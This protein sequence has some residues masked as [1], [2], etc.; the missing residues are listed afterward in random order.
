MRKL[1]NAEIA[2]VCYDTANALVSV[3]EERDTVIQ[4]L[5]TLTRQR[6][7][8][9]LAALMHT[10]GVNLDKSHEA[11]SL[12]LEKE[13]ESGNLPEIQRAVSMI[14]PNMGIKTASLSSDDASS[15]EMHPFEAFLVEGRL[16]DVG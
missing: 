14:S 13:A 10:K 7:A 5:A 9:K 4:K 1:S 6:E 3:T 12:D 16:G 11:L 2:Q 8:E 15:A